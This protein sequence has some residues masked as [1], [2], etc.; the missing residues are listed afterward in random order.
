M[1]A[2][3]REVLVRAMPIRARSNSPSGKRPRLLAL[4][5]LGTGALG[6]ALQ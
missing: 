2:Q 1:Q 6:E 4:T 3:E 5:F